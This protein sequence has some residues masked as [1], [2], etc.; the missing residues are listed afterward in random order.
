MFH[1]KIKTMLLNEKWE[2][3]KE[4]VFL[5]II[6]RTHEII[7]LNKKY[8][9]IVNI[10]HNYNKEHDIYVIIEEYTDDDNLIKKNNI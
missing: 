3:I 2:V 9:R 4:K 8:Y 1:K 7:Y 5:K 6:P 10:I